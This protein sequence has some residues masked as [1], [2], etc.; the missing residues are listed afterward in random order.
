MCCNLPV[1]TST[2]LDCN[3]KYNLHNLALQRSM[4]AFEILEI[5]IWMCPGSVSEVSKLDVKLEV[6]L[7]KRWFFE[8]KFQY[9]VEL[10]FF[11]NKKS[12]VK[13]KWSWNFSS[14]SKNFD[15]KSSW[16]MRWCGVGGE[17]WFFWIL[18]RKSPKFSRSR[19]RRSRLIW[20]CSDRRVSL[21]NRCSRNR[22]LGVSPHMEYFR[23]VYGTLNHGGR[24]D[25][26]YIQFVVCIAGI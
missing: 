13:L 8:K 22:V 21:K 23:S 3:V 12:D 19:L 1:F 18:A 5:Q 4:K 11:S 6:K 9:E 25:I 20:L 17:G 14:R 7:K 26:K 24:W 10:G 15:V 2:L 16:D